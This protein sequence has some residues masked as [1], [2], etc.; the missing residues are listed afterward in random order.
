MESPEVFTFSHPSPVRLRIAHM[1]TSQYAR[2]ISDCI[3]ADG[4]EDH[5]LA[6]DAMYGVY[7]SWCALDRQ[8]PQSSTAFWTAMSDLG[9]HE[10][11]RISRRYIRPGLR[12]TG[13]AAVDYVLA[14]RPSMV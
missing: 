3:A 10:R 7:I 9:L 8:P 12:M 2:F 1:T 4:G 13:P 11:R 6:E 14:S 5:G